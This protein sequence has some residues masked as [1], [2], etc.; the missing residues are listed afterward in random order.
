MSRSL[1]RGSLLTLGLLGAALAPAAAQRST[2]VG[3]IPLQTF[4]LDNGLKVLLVPDRSTPTVAVNV[5]YD[6]GARNEQPGLTGFAHLFEHMMFEGSANVGKGE[7]MTLLQRAGASNLNGTT[8]EDRTNYYQVV[9]PNRVNLALWLEA[10]RMRALNVTAENLKNQQDV[11]KEE[12][13]MRVDNAP[14][15]AAINAILSDVGYNPQ[16]CFAYGH[17]TIGSM[18]DLEA[19]RLEDVQQ[20]FRTYYAPNN[21]TLAVV[22]DIDPAQTRALIEEY[23]GSIPRAA[24]A[25]AVECREPFSHLPV[26]RTMQDPNATLPAFVAAYGTVPFEHPDRYALEI[27]ASIL[28]EGASSRLNQR[29]VQEERA[30]QFAFAG[31]LSRRGPGQV[32][33]YSIANQG[34]TAERLEALVDEEVEKIR[35]RGV[36]AAELQRVKNQQRAQTIRGLQSSFGRSEAIQQYNLFA[37]DPLG[38]REAL[39]RYDAVTR[40]DIQRVA[41]QYLAPNNRAVI[42]NVPA[43][44]S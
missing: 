23:F 2:A 14:Y 29:L 7:H 15:A 17:M 19:A 22:G 21:A 12:K 5:W 3:E 9:P 6:V 27:L 33:V 20:F 16:T 31:A 18:E 42:H 36:T 8:S 24:E 1:V 44:K 13:R 38:F 32:V 40:E 37:G 41:R 26:R 35:T 34:V 28:G 10:D 30:A 25:P 43:P 4:E 11:V 39:E